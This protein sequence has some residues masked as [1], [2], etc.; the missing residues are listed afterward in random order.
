VS[1]Q[2]EPRLVEKQGIRLRAATIPRRRAAHR[3]YPVL[4]ALTYHVDRARFDAL[5]LDN[6]RRKGADV[7]GWSAPTSDRDWVKGVSPTERRA[8]A[9][10]RADVVIDATGRD[11]C[12]RADWLAPPRSVA[13]QG[14]ALHAV[15]GAQARRPRH[16]RRAHDHALAAALVILLRATS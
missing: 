9:R 12:S 14:R 15:R 3:E 8:A 7:R 5:L 16:D 6:A 4:P 1:A 13:E 10:D 2:I 11:C